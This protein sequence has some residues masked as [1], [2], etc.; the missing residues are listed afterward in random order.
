MTKF[1]YS[2][3]ELKD[4]N[5]DMLMPKVISEK[6]DF[7]MRRFFIKNRVS[8]MG[9]ERPVYPMDRNGFIMSSNLLIK[10]VPNLDLNLRILGFLTPNCV[11][12]DKDRHDNLDIDHHIIYHASAGTVYGVS[13]GCYYEFGI[14]PDIVDGKTRSSN[15]L[16]ISD[17]FPKLGELNKLKKSNTIGGYKT[18]LDTSKLP[19]RFYVDK[20]D[21]Y[22]IGAPRTGKEA[23]DKYKV[24]IEISEP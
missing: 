3:D 6:H 23:F 17:I 2:F 15:I 16:N 13:K 8:V 14:R 19:S 9:R 18:I 1:G 22:K 7:L 4:Q 20:T 10:V 21:F 5:V 11:E 12:F 24:K